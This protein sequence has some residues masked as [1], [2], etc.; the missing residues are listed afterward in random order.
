MTDKE[1]AALSDAVA[2]LARMRRRATDPMRSLDA[3]RVVDAQF[4]EE[5]CDDAIALLTPPSEHSWDS[6]AGYDRCT[7][8]FC[9]A[10]RMTPAQATDP[11][12]PGAGKPL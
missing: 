11:T 8:P 4:I 5:T 6:C 1:R 9:G 12:K 3:G 2:L 10:T 7:D